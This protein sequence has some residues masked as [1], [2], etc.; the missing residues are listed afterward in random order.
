MANCKK[1][2]ICG[3]SG[4][5]KSTLLKEL[6]I[7]SPDPDWTFSD[8]DQLILASR[9]KG[10][11]QL[12]QVI[13]NYGWEK[14]RLWERQEIDSWIK[15]DQKGVLSL[16][17]GALS[18][19]L[20]SAYLPIKKIKFC[21]LHASFEDCWKRLHMPGTENRP[22]LRQG[23]VELEKIYNQRAV[24]FSQIPWV[25]DN[26]EGQELGS[27]ALQFWDYVGN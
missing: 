21:Y 3:F 24:L 23:Q 7:S 27:L 20:L 15:E 17:G 9:G 14:F 13:E 2:L 5:G 12:E 16:G 25:L 6:S 26:S 1:I 4:A 19:S 8:L 11:S 10:L 22:L 18:I